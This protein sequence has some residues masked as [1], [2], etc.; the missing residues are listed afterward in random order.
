MKITECITK[1]KYC[2]DIQG[3]HLLFF[4][5]LVMLENYEPPCIVTINI[6]TNKQTLD[7]RANL[8]DRKLGL[9]VVSDKWFKTYHHPNAR[10][11]SVNL[12][13]LGFKIR[14]EK[15]HENT[16]NKTKKLNH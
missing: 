3:S 1:Q 8:A 5:W 12:K 9:K 4:T 11:Y 15:N 6:D 16:L 7:R 14:T 10:E 2:F 13:G